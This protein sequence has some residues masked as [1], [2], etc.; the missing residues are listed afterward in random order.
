VF[1]SLTRNNCSFILT[2]T[3]S[4]CTLDLVEYAMYSWEESSFLSTMV[5]EC[6][7]GKLGCPS[8]FLRI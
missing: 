6:Y 4:I 2:L 8:N 3:M 1:L 5:I 7:L